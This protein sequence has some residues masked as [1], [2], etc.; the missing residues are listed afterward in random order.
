MSLLE[1]M[2]YG[3]CC[4]TSDIPE[5]A[6]VIAGVG[7]TFKRGGVDA[8]RAVLSSTIATPA[9]VADCGNAARKR[10]ADLYSWDSAVRRTLDAYE[11]TE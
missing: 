9:C 2:A 6:D 4:L 5:C 1:A 10:V 8:L 11:G 7:T 3:C